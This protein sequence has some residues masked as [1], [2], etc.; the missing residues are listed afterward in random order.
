M[1][2]GCSAD[3]IILWERHCLTSKHQYR[4][5]T[6]VAVWKLKA[7]K[8]CLFT[9]THPLAMTGQ[10]HCFAKALFSP[11]YT[12]L[13]KQMYYFWLTSPLLLWLNGIKSL[14]PGGKSSQNKTALG[15]GVRCVT[16]ARV[17]VCMWFWN[18]VDILWGKC[19]FNFIS[20]AFVFFIF[21]GH[22]QP[23]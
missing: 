9:E 22:H 1:L 16:I 3:Q 20:E 7:T 11:V 8:D 15:F 5:M 18:I 6:T 19:P 17:Q 4:I 2:L 14:K 21:K 10:R 23:F 13:P 12:K